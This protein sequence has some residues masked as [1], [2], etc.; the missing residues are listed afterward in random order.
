VTNE[1]IQFSRNEAAQR[2]EISLDGQRVGLA[3]YVERDGVVA[4]P[5]TEI[6]PTSGGQGLA[7]ALVEYA[8]D[9]LAARGMQVIPACSFVAAYIQQN[10]QYAGLVAP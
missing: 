8:L 7:G 3:D 5:H 2:Y 6:D 4:I 9:D 1:R 10:P